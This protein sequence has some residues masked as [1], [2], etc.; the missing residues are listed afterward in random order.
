MKPLRD[1][2]IGFVNATLMLVV[3]LLV[4][5]TIFLGRLNALRDGT[6]A[7]VV[8]GLAPYETQLARIGDEL[9]ALNQKIETADGENIAA[10]RDELAALRARL[11]DLSRLEALCTGEIVQQ[12]AQGLA[13][14]LS[15]QSLEGAPSSRCERIA[16][17]TEVAAATKM[18]KPINT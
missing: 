15:G 9:E 10:L 12:V 6:V 3:L 5:V 2:A 14:R 18:P 17:A 16:S 11:P 1:L 13:A 4:V 8:G 7:A